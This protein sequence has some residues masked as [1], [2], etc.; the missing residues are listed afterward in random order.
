M[1]PFIWRF[2]LRINLIRPWHILHQ[3][4]DDLQL[5]RLS[6]DFILDKCYANGAE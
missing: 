5:I 4:K 2:C 6:H 3:E 1:M